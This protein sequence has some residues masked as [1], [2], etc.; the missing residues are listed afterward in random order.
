[1]EA[2]LERLQAVQ[3]TLDVVQR[4]TLDNQLT[5][6][7]ELLAQVTEDLTTVSVSRS[8]RVLGLLE[9]KI[10]DLRDHVGAKL[11]ECWNAYVHIDST[12]SAIT[13]GQIPECKPVTALY[14]PF[15]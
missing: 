2:T 6:A 5:K 9:A 4:A 11:L 14:S 12:K 15:S 7:V 1:M 10:T 13:I 3:K 8:T